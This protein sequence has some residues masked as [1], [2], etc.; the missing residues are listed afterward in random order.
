MTSTTSKRTSWFWRLAVAAGLWLAAIAASAQILDRVDVNVVGNDAVLR[1]EFN[2]L[3]QYLRNVP[4]SHGTAVRIYFQ[5]TGANDQGAGVV[6]EERRAQPDKLLPQFR[7]TYPAQ[8]PGIQRYID[9]VFDAAVDFRVQPEGNNRFLVYVRLS[10]QQLEKLRAARSAGRTAPATTT[11]T[12]APPA[13]APQVTP[14]ATTPLPAPPPT[15]A[16]TIA[17]SAVQPPVSRPSRGGSS[18][19]ATC[20]G[21]TDHNATRR[22]P[23]D[24]NA[25]RSGRTDHNATRR[26]PSDHNATRRDRTDRNTSGAGDCGAPRRVAA[27]HRVDRSRL[28]RRQAGGDGHR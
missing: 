17:P 13:T 20:F 15:A 6:E 14:P 27:S 9:V 18:A 11:P 21:R 28:R 7:V 23:S 26:G 22:G 8:L 16:A 24:H 19:S 12:A 10:P 25:A 5:I 3:V 1:I 2:V 4:V